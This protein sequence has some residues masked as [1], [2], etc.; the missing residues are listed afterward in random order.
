[1]RTIAAV[2][3]ARSD[4]ALMLPVFRAVEAESALRLRLVV[5]GAHLAADFGM[6][7]DDVAAD[8]FEVAARVATVPPAD[9][10]ADISVAMGHAVT[11]F[12]HAL[13]RVAPDLVLVLGDRWEMHAAAL[14]ALPLRIPVAHVHGGESSEGAIDDALRHSLTKLSH[15]HF[16]AAAAYGR[17]IV[18]MGEEPWRVVV[19]GAP[20]LDGIEG[21]S[22]LVPE[23]M[24]RRF[25][26]DVDGD[27]LLVTFHPPTLEGDAREQVAE[28]IA[29]VDAS[30]L[31]AIFTAPGVDARARDVLAAVRSFA[32]ADPRH[33]F[34]TSFGRDGYLSAL[35]RA[36]AVVGNSSSGI[37]EAASF[38]VPVVDVGSRQRG[39]IR[40]ANVIDSGYARGDVLTAIR[41]AVSDEFRASLAGLENPYA[42]GGAAPAIVA[43]LRDVQLGESLVMKRFHDLGQK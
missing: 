26:V 32:D 16:P 38:G 43:R 41:R 36:R 40:G 20:G 28:L 29:A 35:A 22:P 15:L 19:S 11:A 1:V 2:T 4:Y 23:E 37:I 24:R 3:V 25:G 12:A 14:A 42:Q 10:A 6:T 17:R 30:G 8:G 34:V 5:A 9:T 7:A 21:F 39:R 27:F 13:A 33:A 31:A 18:Q